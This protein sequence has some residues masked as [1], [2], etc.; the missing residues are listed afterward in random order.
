[1]THARRDCPCRGRLCPPRVFSLFHSP[2]RMW[3][4]G[5]RHNGVGSPRLGREGRG[6]EKGSEGAGGS[7][8]FRV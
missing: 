8:D 2:P 1:M 5:R 7:K 4:R 6:G 3:P